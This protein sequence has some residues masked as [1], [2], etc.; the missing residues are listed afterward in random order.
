MSDAEETFDA[1][2][3]AA[4]EATDAQIQ[5]VLDGRPDADAPAA[6][7]WLSA[8]VRTDPPARLAARIEERHERVLRR[9]WRP[10]RYA[11][12]AM[13]YLY[14]SQGLG[15]LFIG[16]WIAE[17]IGEDFSPHLTR[18]G[19]FAL[20]AVGIAVLAGVLRRNLVPVSVVS[21]VPLG[22]AL[23][24]SGIG[25]IGVFAAGAVLHITEG[26]VAVVLAVTAW[27][28]WRDTSRPPDEEGT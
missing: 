21:G 10:V 9:R 19:G 18:E 14:I 22:I 15:N 20:I 8:A 5:S 27:R 24:I 12:A 16:S 3:E 25:E 26:I 11:A 1:A 4:A 13:A 23:G 2:E 28:F 17:G 7:T 6:I